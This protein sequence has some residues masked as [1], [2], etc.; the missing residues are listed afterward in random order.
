MKLPEGEKTLCLSYAEY[1]LRLFM[2]LR[3]NMVEIFLMAMKIFQV[4]PL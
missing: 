2:Y 1:F 3:L 4:V